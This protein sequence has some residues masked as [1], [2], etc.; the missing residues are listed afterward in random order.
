[1]AQI[2][3]KPYACKWSNIFHYRK[4]GYKEVNN[5]SFSLKDKEIA[6]FRDQF[7]KGSYISVNEI[8]VDSNVF[9]TTWTIYDDG[10]EISTNDL[11]KRN[12]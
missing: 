10:K 5:G 7:R 2:I 8:G 3:Q 11:K 9:E 6:N 12:K 4:N 1:M